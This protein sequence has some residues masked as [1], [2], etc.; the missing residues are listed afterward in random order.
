MKKYNVVFLADGVIRLPDVPQESFALLQALGG[1]CPLP[2]KPKKN[3]RNVKRLSQLGEIRTGIS[4]FDSLRTSSLWQ[5]HN[6]VLSDPDSATDSS[7]L[8]I[9]EVKIELAR[10]MLFSCQMC[11]LR[12]GTDRWHGERGECG[13]GREAYYTSCFLNWGEERHLVPSITLFLNGCNWR[14]PYCQYPDQLEPENGQPLYTDETVEL[15]RRLIVKGGK[16]L[17]WLGGNPDQHLWSTLQVIQRL[18]SEIPIVWNTNGYASTHTMNLLNGIVDT[19]IIDF[20]YGNNECATRYKA[21]PMA[22]EVL[23]RNL[24]L[25]NA[26]AG[27][28]IVRHLQLPGHLECCTIPILEWLAEELPD[29]KVNLMNEEYYPIHQTSQF[30]EIDR[31]LTRA[32]KRRAL[33][34]AL[35][36]ELHLIH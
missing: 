22:W 33:E 4:D 26:Q 11:E 28:V 14:C 23:K 27:E 6:D 21:G 29:V 5:I 18:S 10:R 8:S 36:L 3:E 1:N 34:R 32:E 31:R 7:G 35:E 25:A 16:N 13:S 2:A 19:Y 24:L 30:P 15:I 12:C 20:R 17:H 9:L